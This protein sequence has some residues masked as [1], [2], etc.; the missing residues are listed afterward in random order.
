MPQ[1][2]LGKPVAE[3]VY[4]SLRPIIPQLK[5]QPRLVVLLVGEDPAS[6]VYVRNKTTACEKLG[7]RGETVQLPAMI[8]QAEL[9]AHVQR[10]NADPSVHGILV[11]L[12]LPPGLNKNEILWSIRPEKDVDGIHPSNL[13]KLVAAKPSLVACTPSGIMEMLKFYRIDVAGKNAVVIG[14]S[15]IVGKPMAQL[16][17][18]ADATV[19]VCHSKTQNLAAVTKRADILIAALG[20]PRAVTAD[21]VKPGAVVV[22]V[23]IHRDSNGKLCGDVDEAG[24]GRVASHLSPVPGGVGPLTIAM[25]MKNL[26]TAAKNAQK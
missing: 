23:G 25:L 5:V 11:Q 15:E 16:L 14:R 10:L 22:D 18:N 21:F 8:T 26:I 1:L 13:G 24:V 7:L 4:D 3:Q 12:P 20:K 2:M 17:I 6:H 9:L 19:T